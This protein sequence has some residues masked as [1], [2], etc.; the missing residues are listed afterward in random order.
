MQSEFIWNDG[1]R[2]ACGFVGLAGDC[3]TRSIAIATGTAYRDV[4]SQLGEACEAS[5]RN[6]VSTSIAAKYLQDRGWIRGEFSVL[7][8]PTLLPMGRVIVHVSKESLRCSHFTALVDQVVHDTWDPSEES[9]YYIREYWTHPELNASS[10]GSAETRSDAQELTQAEFDK[11]LNRLR[12]L[13]NTAKNHASTEA[14]K[15]NALRM[16]QSL[17]LRHNLSRDDIGANENLDALQFTR[18]ACAL[19]GRRSCAWEKSLAHYICDEILPMTQWYSGTNGNRSLI[20]FY[21][22]V[23]DVRNAVSLF[24]EMVVTIAAAAHLQFGGFSRGSGAS[25]AEGYVSGLPRAKNS[26][27]TN[28]PSGRNT[29]STDTTNC[30]ALI[31]AR[32]L[33]IHSVA[34]NWLLNE[35]DIHLVT[36]RRTGRYEHDELAEKRGFIHGSQHDVSVPNA[37]K[38][39]GSK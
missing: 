35:C 26:M 34:D 18:M 36:S 39:I 27:E 8:C 25:Y 16:M 11:I 20:W 31:A 1:G 9:V 28:G 17:M 19:S 10:N 32:T 22:P 12:A 23:Q 6:G 14:E 5:P 7:F 4:Y 29:G 2:S 30:Q 24:R 37:P 33:A 21:G 15:H 13:D 3:V 38:R